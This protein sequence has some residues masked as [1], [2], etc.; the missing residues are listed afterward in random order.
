M[1]VGESAAVMVVNT[2]GQYLSYKKRLYP[3]LAGGCVGLQVV[4]IAVCGSLLWKGLGVMRWG[5]KAKRK[6]WGELKGR[7]ELQALRA[8]FTDSN[9]GCNC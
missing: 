7:E 1:W 8:F 2:R 6:Q 4:F 5:E 3:A 9:K